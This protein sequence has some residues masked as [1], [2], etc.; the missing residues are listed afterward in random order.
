MSTETPELNITR[1]DEGQTGGEQ[2]FNEGAQTLDTMVM[3][4]FQDFNVNTPPVSPTSGQAWLLGS[5]P[6]GV[7]AGHG[8][9]VAFWWTAPLTFLSA[10]HFVTPQ[11]GWRAWHQGVGG[12]GV[13]KTFGAGGWVGGTTVAALGGGETDLDV[14]AAKIND[15]MDELRLHGLQSA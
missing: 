4:V 7:W 3:L 11:I 2:L 12:E 13:L 1:I 14:I 9:E 6:T 8:N 10:W 5:S 15:I